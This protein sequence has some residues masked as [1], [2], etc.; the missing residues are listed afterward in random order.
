MGSSAGALY[1][2][3]APIMPYRDGDLNPDPPNLFY[4]TDTLSLMY[5]PPSAAQTGVVKNLGNGNSQELVVQPQMNCGVDKHD[6]LCGFT[7]G[8]RAL[9]Y[10]IDGAWDTMT[11]TNIQ[12]EALHLQ[13]SG[14]L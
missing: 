11:L 4:R 7:D 9:I 14:K 2:F 6:Q 5:V 10:D 13:H 1:N 3:F 8:T 12:D